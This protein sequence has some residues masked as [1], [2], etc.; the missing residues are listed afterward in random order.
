MQCLFV[1]APSC[2]CLCVCLCV[3][4]RVCKHSGILRCPRDMSARF[5]LLC[6]LFNEF[7]A[8][9]DSVTHTP[10]WPELAKDIGQLF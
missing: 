7:I 5:Q 8:C 9:W 6:E 4:V 1:C 10:R 3:C 2:V